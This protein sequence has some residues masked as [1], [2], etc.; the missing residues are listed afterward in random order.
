MNMKLTKK[1]LNDN[2][3]ILK[4]ARAIMEKNK[5][6][7]IQ[8][9]LSQMG[10]AFIPHE[11]Q[12]LMYYDA[13]LEGEQKVELVSMKDEQNQECENTKEE[14]D[15]IMNMKL[16]KQILRDN[17]IYNSW[18]ISKRTEVNIFIIYFPVN[19]GIAY[20]SARWETIEI[21]SDKVGIFTNYIKLEFPVYN[22][23]DKEN[24]LE[25]AKAF[26]LKKYGL[27][28]T[29]KDVFGN[30]HPEG[31]LDKLKELINKNNSQVV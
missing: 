6:T 21:K 16:T 27:K 17:K 25:K 29:D 3:I 5:Q 11:E 14:G 7:K 9:K 22:I 2:N 30:W 8:R 24:E 31:T 12:F 23:K 28:V 26:V 1:I 18:N 20:H 10:T 4:G 13:N 19:S 15:S